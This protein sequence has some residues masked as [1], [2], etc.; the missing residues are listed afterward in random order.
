MSSKFRLCV[1][2]AAL[3]GLAGVAHAA[4]GDVYDAHADFS[5]ASNPAGTWSYGWTPTLGGAFTLYDRNVDTLGNA[6]LWNATAPRSSLVPAAWNNPTNSSI[7]PAGLDPAQSAAFHPGES[8]EFSVFRFTVPSSGSYDISG[9]MTVIDSGDTR[10]Y[11]VIN[12][13]A[14]FDTGEMHQADGAHAFSLTATLASGDTVDFV[15]GLGTSNS[16]YNDSTML[17]ATLTDVPEPASAVLLLGGLAALRLRR[18]G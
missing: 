16:Y 4:P 15:V 6:T 11:V 3:L 18:R 8:G 13:A 2:S 5:I 7:Q 9:A 14:I 17:S 10:G 12:G 1:L